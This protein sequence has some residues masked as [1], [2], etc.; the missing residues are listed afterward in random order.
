MSDRN[1]NKKS[2]LADFFRYQKDKLSGK[3][4]NSFERELQ[5]DNFAREAAE[6]YYSGIRGRRN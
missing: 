4:R 2:L 1:K 5:K 6:G 3:E